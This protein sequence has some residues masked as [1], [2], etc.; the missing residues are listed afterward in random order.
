MPTDVFLNCF[1]QNAFQAKLPVDLFVCKL[2]VSNFRSL[3]SVL[4]KNQPEVLFS[5]SCHLYYNPSTERRA[6]FTTRL[7]L[8]FHSLM[9]SLI[10]GSVAPAGPAEG[11]TFPDPH[12]APGALGSWWRVG[13]GVEVYGNNTTKWDGSGRKHLDKLCLHQQQ[14]TRF[15]EQTNNYSSDYNPA[16]APVWKTT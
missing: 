11:G 12:K 15:Q 4:E 1:Y 8:N 10:P 9:L 13:M 16:P 6:W 2:P 3:N 5:F 7:N 14:Q